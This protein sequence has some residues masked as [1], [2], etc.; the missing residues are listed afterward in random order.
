MID[1]TVEQTSEFESLEDA[2]ASSRLNRMLQ[3][4]RDLAQLPICEPSERLR[5][6]GV[7]PR[8]TNQPMAASSRIFRIMPAERSPRL[9]AR[10][11]AR[12]IDSRAGPRRSR[13]SLETAA[14]RIAR[15]PVI[16]QPGDAFRRL[17][18]VRALDYRWMKSRYTS[19]TR[20]P[21]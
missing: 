20:A 12:R 6:S 11:G 16:P 1:E 2:E 13:L 7:P 8:R 10:P 4:R 15:M 17:R 14:G 9:A 5:E 18:R 19:A 3:Q 21:T